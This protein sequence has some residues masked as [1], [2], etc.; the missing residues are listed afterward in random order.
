MLGADPA[1]AVSRKL[2]TS[3]DLGL[4]MIFILPL[5]A[6][7]S[8]AVMTYLLI[9][10]D[11]AYL[12]LVSFVLVISA[13]ALFAAQALRRLNPPRHEKFSGLL[14]LLLTNTALFGVALLNVQ[15]SH[16]LIGSLLFGLGSGLGFALVLAV[17]PP[18]QERLAA[19]DVPRPFRGAAIQLITLGLLSL[20]FMGFT[21]LTRL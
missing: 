12:E 4:A 14:P 11:L 10:L 18:L 9:P 3:L 6:V 2:R 13:A 15:H 19:A 17:L 20:A 21:G 1:L 16:G 5:V 7:L 8:Y